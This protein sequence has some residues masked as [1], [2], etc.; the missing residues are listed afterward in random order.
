MSPEATTGSE[1]IVGTAGCDSA[2]GS[3]ACPERERSDPSAASRSSSRRRFASGDPTELAN[4][5]SSSPEYG[6]ARRCSAS[7]FARLGGSVRPVVLSASV[8]RRAYPRGIS[9]HPGPPAFR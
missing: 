8:A 7:I 9:Q 2:G 4:T 1:L 6:L 5:K 3:G